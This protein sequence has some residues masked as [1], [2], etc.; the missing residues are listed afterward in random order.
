MVEFTAEEEVYAGYL[1]R[2]EKIKNAA[3]QLRARSHFT[4]VYV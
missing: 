3:N 2:A 4:T 1:S